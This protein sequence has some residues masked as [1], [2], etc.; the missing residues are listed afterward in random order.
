MADRVQQRVYALT[1]H[2]SPQQGGPQ[3]PEYVNKLYAPFSFV[4]VVAQAAAPSPPVDTAKDTEIARLREQLAQAQRPVVTAVPSDV[5]TAVPSEPVAKV[6][7]RNAAPMIDGYEILD[8][9]VL[10]QASL[11]R[12]PKTGLVWQRCSVGQKWNGSTCTGQAKT[13][14]FENAQKLT[15]NGWRVPTVRELHSLVWCSSG[16]TRGQVDPKDG[17]LVIG[18]WCDNSQSPA[19]SANAFPLTPGR[20]DYWS[21]SPYVGYVHNA[22]FVN[23]DNGYVGYNNRYYDGYAVR[24][25]RASQ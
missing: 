19:I 10:G 15:G 21:S 25:V 12:D 22:R 16:Q 20:L 5:V 13:F 18:H 2:R 11:A 6:S 8:D 3:A 9:P 17:G 1:A 14:T 7:V 4:P 24:L 23:F